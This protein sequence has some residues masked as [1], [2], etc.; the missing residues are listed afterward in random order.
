MT[1]CERIKQQLDAAIDV[2]QDIVAQ[3][4]QP[5]LPPAERAQLVRE[6]KDIGPVIADLRRRHEQ[7]SRSPKAQAGPCRR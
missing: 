7:C 3:M 4:R 6:L 2:R 1:S 5:N